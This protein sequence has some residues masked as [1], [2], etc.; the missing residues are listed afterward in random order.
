MTPDAVQKAFD[1]HSDGKD[2][3]KAI[4]LY[5]E[6][7]S[8]YPDD[9][10]IYINLGA[11][12]RA[13]GNAEEAAQLL[14]TGLI[15]LKQESPAILNNLG[16]ALR[17]LSRYSEAASMYI[18]ALKQNTH[19]H[20]AD[21]SLY[22]CFQELGLHSLAKI[23]LKMIHI[24][25][26]K[27]KSNV[28]SL[29]IDYEIQAALRENRSLNPKVEDLLQELNCN[30][31]SDKRNPPQHWFSTSIL[32]AS[33]G[34]LNESLRFYENGLKSLA[35]FK[36]AENRKHSIEE[37]NSMYNINSWNLSCTLLRE[38]DF[39]NGWK[40]YDHGLRT[41]AEGAQRWQRSLFKPASSE[42]IKIWRGEQ[43]S[44][45]NI[46]LLGE[47]GIGDSMQFIVCVQKIIDVAENITII[48]PDRIKEIYKRSLPSCEI[49]GSEEIRKDKS[50][51]VC[52]N[53]DYQSPL[54]S[55]VQYTC[56]SPEEISAISFKLRARKKL[57]DKLRKR[58]GSDKPLIGI[59]WQGGGR[60]KR[61]NE[62]SIP[63]ELLC[64]ELKDLNGRFI[65]LQYGDDAHIVEKVRKAVQI[66]LIDDPEIQ[67][68]QDMETWLDQVDACDYVISIANT[69]IHGAGGLN[70][71]TFCILGRKADWRWLKNPST[72][73]WYPSVT[74]SQFEDEGQHIKAIHDARDWLLERMGEHAKIN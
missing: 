74:V 70:K 38:G 65:S 41:P 66:D 67:A 17:D 11:L 27:K 9:K 57:V 25:Y 53:Y 12:L 5:R 3:Q 72:S 48:L 55:I 37:L 68:V 19:Y 35:E 62:K 15:R 1:A 23:Y 39:E 34:K 32:C 63:L 10:R 54:G 6:A 13:E 30:E 22:A 56:R 73:Y 36:K 69:T 71:P 50:R 28:A 4:L 61:L 45:K 51:F 42:K 21:T 40:L 18:R 14:Q 64:R 43:L 44:G 2:K 58:Y 31:E 52:S 47:Q 49:I 8:Q 46:L 24:K 59:S 33:K 26:K 29:V 20:D 16:N 60:G 7:L